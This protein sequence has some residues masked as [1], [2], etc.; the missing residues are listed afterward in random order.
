[1]APRGPHLLWV[2]KLQPDIEP[3]VRPTGPA[4]APPSPTLPDPD[5]SPTKQLEESMPIQEAAAA[6]TS[7][8]K[9][10]VRGNKDSKELGLNR[11]TQR[12]QTEVT[13]GAI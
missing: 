12:I 7:T 9:K 13:R 8:L 11:T 5:S 10:S 3:M 1:M 4:L 2:Y 6:R